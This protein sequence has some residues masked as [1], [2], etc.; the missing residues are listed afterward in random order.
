MSDETPRG[1]LPLLAAAQAQKHV[2]HNEALLAL[3]ALIGARIL[4][5]DRTAPPASPTDGDTY[6]VHATA[7]GA[8]AG[9]EGQI[10]SCLDGAW[11]FHAPFA[12]L[13]A[14]IAGE[15]KFLL[16]DGTAWVDI[17]TLLTL[18][19]L[20]L[21]GINTAAD[22]TN[23]LA[24]KSAAVLFDNTGSGVQAKLNKHAAGDTASLLYQ[25]NYSGRA[26]IGLSG[27]D[28]FH[29]KVSPDGSAWTEALKLDKTSGLAT[30]AG[31]PTS[32]LHAATK[33]YV[34]V[35][36]ASL[37]PLDSDLTAIAALAP[38]NDDVL[39]RKS[40][41]WTS[42]TPAQL[43]SDLALG[44][45]ENTALSGWAGSA[46]LTALGTVASGT[47]HG[48]PLAD[49]YIASAG[50]WNAKLASGDIGGTIQAHD[51]DLDAIAALAATNDDVIQRKS[52]AWTNRTLVQLGA[53]LV[54]A[55][56][57][58]A[59]GE[60]VASWTWSANV[61]NVDFTGLSAYR[62]LLVIAHGLQHNSGSSQN[63]YLR[64][65]TDNGASFASA[66]YANYGNGAV[67][68]QVQVSAT[69]AST[70]VCAFEARIADFNVAARRTL[71]ALTQFQLSTTSSARPSLVVRDVA[72]SNNALRLA[73]SG[74]A[75]AAG[76]I[77]IYGRK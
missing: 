75:I 18:Q 48:T 22:A 47:W 38:S 72:E 66:S 52:G 15:D 4:D 68:D 9:K 71:A 17:S 57:A 58:G 12:G 8:W 36:A 5:R 30:L 40:G 60:P 27:D 7:T 2:T 50:A 44:N 63:F 20:P 45:V 65:S 19:N 53:D 77:L 21:V 25:T 67:T 1:A 42:R 34:D 32:A 31:D 29:F 54:A 43:K 74:G 41:A 33:Q 64:T 10:A 24:V 76:T 51:A 39:Q 55:G 46:A 61:A 35:A 23:K 13:T 14:Y 37:Q 26:E 28:H 62:E 49:A 3:D 56:T 59:W 69:I 73:V 16:F 70:I 6:L 11:R